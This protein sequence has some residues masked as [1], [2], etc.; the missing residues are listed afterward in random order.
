MHSC[1]SAVPRSRTRSSTPCAAEFGDLPGWLDI[2]G[3]LFEALTHDEDAWQVEVARDPALRQLLAARPDFHARAQAAACSP[4]AAQRSAARDRRDR[5]RRGHVLGRH[6]PARARARGLR[7]ARGPRRSRRVHAPTRSDRR[8]RARCAR[9]PRARGHDAGA[10]DR[11]QRG[12]REHGSPGS[13]RSRRRVS[14]ASSATSISRPAPSS[15][16]PLASHSVTG[17]DAL[18]FGVVLA[19]PTAR[20]R[21]RGAHHLAPRSRRGSA[22]ARA[23]ARRRAHRSRCGRAL[24]HGRSP[25][26]PAASPRSSRRCVNARIRSRRSNSGFRSCASGSC[27]GCRAMTTSPGRADS[28][29]EMRSAAMRVARAWVPMFAIVVG[30]CGGDDPA[31]NGGSSEATGADSS[32]GDPSTSNTSPTGNPTD[33]STRARVRRRVSTTRRARGPTRAPPVR[34]T[35]APTRTAATRASSSSASATTS[36]TTRT[37]GAELRPV[38]ADDRQPL[39]R[40]E[41]SGHRA[42]SSVWCSSATRSPVGTPPTSP[43][44]YYRSVLADALAAEFGLEFG[45]GGDSE[46]PLE[47]RQRLRRHEHRA[48]LRRLRELCEVGRA[49]RRP[50]AGQP[51]LDGVLPAR[52]ARVS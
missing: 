16:T 13:S 45:T 22:R 4:R 17:R 41:P 21:A 50:V 23:V 51:Q 6:G 3:Y 18:V 8:H 7:R 27:S 1:T 28:L 25:G 48:L 24:R 37:L 42:A 11:G 5:L 20:R 35:T 49:Q 14:A 39:P 2:D 47:A 26:I 38:H 19:E 33:A 40:H 10:R 29:G 34:P 31:G 9:Q 44:D 52:D 12:R 46:D 32:G 15:S 30:A 36:S 43:R